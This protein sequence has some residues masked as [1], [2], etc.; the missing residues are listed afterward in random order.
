M[1]VSNVFWFCFAV[2][3]DL[4]DDLIH[5]VCLCGGEER[6]EMGG[7]LREEICRSEMNGESESLV[8]V[9]LL[10]LCCNSTIFV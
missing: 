10:L 3:E 8:V 7:E 9:V 4:E 6:S 5:T 2:H 1:H